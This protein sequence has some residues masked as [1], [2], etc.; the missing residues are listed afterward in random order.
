MHRSYAN[1]LRILGEVTRRAV[2]YLPDRTAGDASTLAAG[3]EVV[4]VVGRDE[5]DDARAGLGE[6]LVVIASGAAE[7]LAAERL[8]SVVGGLAELLAL[9]DWLDSA[10]ADLVAREE[11]LDTATASGRRAV[12]LVRELARLEHEG[13]PG[14]PPRGRPGLV[15]RE[16]E[17]VG[18]I[19]RMRE[20][21]LSLQAI[22]DVLNAERVPT[23]RGGARWRPSSVQSALGY[24]RPRPPLPGA[25]PPPPAPPPP[26]A[27]RPASARGGPKAPPP[28][29]ARPRPRRPTRPP[30]RERP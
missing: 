21:G 1:V 28:G 29:A 30:R 19:T 22:A 3:L 25:P 24:R 4:A 14:R 10:G 8:E 20:Q 18:R 11:D 2:L 5:H 17:L 15:A 23:H 7:V 16:P 27:P 26:S 12:S 13:A 9:L 6:A